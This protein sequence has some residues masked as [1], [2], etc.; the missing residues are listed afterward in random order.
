MNV[1]QCSSKCISSI[2]WLIIYDY[3][4]VA[5]RVSILSR[6]DDV[7]PFRISSALCVHFSTRAS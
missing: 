5:L 2:Q 3:Y 1:M 4:V 7:V 6:F